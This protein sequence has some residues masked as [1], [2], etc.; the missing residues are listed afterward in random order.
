MASG[1]VLSAY[2]VM[3]TPQIMTLFVELQ[4]ITVTAATGTE[5]R[6]AL[7]AGKTVLNDAYG[8]YEVSDNGGTWQ[9]AVWKVFATTAY[10]KLFVDLRGSTNWTAATDATSIRGLSA[11]FTVT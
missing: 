11:T 6:I 7:P 1:D 8:I 10:L 2:Y 4:N 3:Q 9:A 5:I